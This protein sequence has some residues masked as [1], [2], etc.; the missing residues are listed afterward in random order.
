MKSLFDHVSEECSKI[1]TRAYS[2]SF[3]LGIYCLNKKI[4]NPIY[5]I[6]GF[7]RFADELVDSFHDFDK[8]VLLEKFKADTY[9]AIE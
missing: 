2:T 5:S 9:E 8:E 7:V 4:R 6:Y 1:T 3:S